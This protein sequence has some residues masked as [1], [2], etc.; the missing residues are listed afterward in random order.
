[1]HSGVT[2]TCT[3]ARVYAHLHTCAYADTRTYTHTHTRAH[4]HAH[5]RMHMK[6]P[7]T[8]YSEKMYLS[9]PNM[10]VNGVVS[11]MVVRSA[12]VLPDV[13][14]ESNCERRDKEKESG[15]R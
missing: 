7:N 12:G 10:S 15:I 11:A 1:M 3:R 2:P 5:T 6:R 8:I 14:T 4:T 9:G 13:G